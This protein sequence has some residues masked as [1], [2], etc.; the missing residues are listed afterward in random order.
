MKHKVMDMKLY[1]KRGGISKGGDM[2]GEA[3]DSVN[4]ARR[5]ER[6]D[7]VRGMRLLR[8]AEVHYM[9]MSKFRRDRERNKRY[10]YGD[11]WGDMICYEGVRMREEDYIRRQGNTPLKNNLIRRLVRN[12]IGVYRSQSSEPIC[13]ARD[14]EEQ[15]LGQTMSTTLQY[16]MQLNR[17]SGLNARAM[18]EFLI[19]GFVVQRKSYG[20]RN[21]KE[22]CWTDLVQPN[23]FFID[24]RMR[25]GRGWDCC[26][27]GEIHDI[28]FED[29]VSEFAKTPGDYDRLSGIYRTARDSRSL[30]SLWEDFGYGGIGRDKSFLVPLDERLCRVIEI[31]KLESKPRYRC[32]DWNSGEIYK[33][34]AEDLEE[35]VLSENRRRGETGRS[36]GMREDE[37]PYID[38]EWTIDRYWYYYY[39]SPTGDIIAEGE[40]PYEHKSHPYVFKAYPFIDGEI[41]SF[42]G[43]VIDQQRYTNRLITMYDWIMRGSAKGV[44]MIPE[45]T[46]PQ[47]MGPEDFADTWT[48]F[49]GVI[50][51]KPSTRH[52]NI[53]QQ[54]SQNSTNIGISEL[55]NVQLKFFE[56]ITGVNG[57]LQGKPGYSGMSAALYSQQMQNGTTSLLDILEAFSE[58]TLDG[59]YKDVKNIQQYYTSRRVMNIAGRKAM[60]EY[61]PDKIRDV[62]FDLSVVPSTATPVYRALANDFLMQIFKTGKITLQQMLEVGNYPFADE[63]LQLLKSQEEQT[64]TGEGGMMIPEEIKEAAAEGADGQAVEALYAA[65]RGDGQKDAYPT[66]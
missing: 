22:D 17:L 21:G 45:D 57:A 33:V 55:L 44:L 52:S 15:R 63:L 16:N 65:L 42:V 20:W 51:Y 25:D 3:F 7:R 60:V 53:P 11:Q 62:E 4:R 13:I 30:T 50:I 48:R 27:L 28:G 9:G 64:P 54:V 12:V 5:E 24:C 61:D 59:A 23:N 58:F 40:S 8:E 56:D 18:E 47:G 34:D 31:W 26:I 49:N 41:H 2:K 39:V 14:R 29:L 66:D 37:I 38:Y 1:R 32:H 10:T 36:V 35:L 19:S 43:D 46:I 6:G